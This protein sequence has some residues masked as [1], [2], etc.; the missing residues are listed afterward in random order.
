MERNFD[1]LYEHDKLASTADV[2]QWIFRY[3]AN[4]GGVTAVCDLLNST[5]HISR[6]G[7]GTWD[8]SEVYKIIRATEYYGQFY[9]GKTDGRK[10]KPIEERVIIQRPDLAL[11]DYDLWSQANA[12]IDEGKG[13]KPKYEF[14]F[15][16]R[17]RCMYEHWMKCQPSVSNGKNPIL[18][19]MNYYYACRRRRLVHHDCT[20]PYFNARIVDGVVFEWVQELL[21]DPQAKIVG[22][23]K[24]Q[25]VA[26][27]EHADITEM[28][29]T[30]DTTL[31]REERELDHL[32]S[33]RKQYRDEPRMLQRVER[34][35]QETLERIERV[36]SNR[37]GYALRLSQQA[38]SDEQVADRIADIERIDATLKRVGTLSFAHRRR[39]IELLDIRIVL[40]VEEERKYVDI[41]WYGDRERRWLDEAPGNQRLDSRTPG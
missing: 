35:I 32:Y 12:V 39:L 3:I 33:D 9:Y 38:M 5:Y 15:S 6:P 24:A 1:R 17:V 10:P 40:G 27:V 16:R 4:R 13:S 36:K 29:A 34:D 23:Q 19:K 2:V 41:L 31:A 21:A 26:S 14:L 28:I 37:Q 7:G 25:K 8:S 22:L 11:V 30:C 18:K 20:L